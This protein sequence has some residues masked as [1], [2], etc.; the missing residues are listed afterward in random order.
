MFKD[1]SDAMHVQPPLP[2]I[3]I[4]G[5]DGFPV[6]SKLGLRRVFGAIVLQRK[7]L[8]GRR[9]SAEGREVATK[10]RTSERSR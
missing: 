5:E 10:D 4:H 7:D 3:S 8:G 6:G 2:E 1:Y 9:W